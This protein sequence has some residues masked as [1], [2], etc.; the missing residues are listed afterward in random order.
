MHRILKRANPAKVPVEEPTKFELV[1]NLKTARA[2]VLVV[3]QGVLLRCAPQELH[4]A[5]V[6]HRRS[7]PQRPYGNC[8]RPRKRVLVVQAA[9]HGF[10]SRERTR[11]P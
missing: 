2:L 5:G 1:I 3:P 7:G 10:R 11:R 9:Q 6:R 8:W 4:P